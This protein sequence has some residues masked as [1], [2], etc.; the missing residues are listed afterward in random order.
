MDISKDNRIGLRTVKHG[1]I[2]AYNVASAVAHSMEMQLQTEHDRAMSKEY[3]E[4][5][6]VLGI[7]ENQIVRINKLIITNKK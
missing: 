5:C 3:G 4:V 6:S 7:L 2:K 1:L